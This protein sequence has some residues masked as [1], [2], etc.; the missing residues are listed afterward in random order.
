MRSYTLLSW[1][2]DGFYTETT[3]QPEQH[4]Y[5]SEKKLEHL[6]VAEEN[7]ILLC[8]EVLTK[9]L[10]TGTKDE[11]NLSQRRFLTIRLTN[12]YF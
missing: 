8:I 5:E 3:Y 4:I 7:N 1:T 6:K 10:G 2:Y 9:T 12:F 11:K